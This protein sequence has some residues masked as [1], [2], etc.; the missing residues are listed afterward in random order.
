MVALLSTSPQVAGD[1]LL[2][3]VYSQHVDLGQRMFCLDAMT[4]AAQEL[5]NEPVLPISLPPGEYSPCRLAWLY[6]TSPCTT[7]TMVLMQRFIDGHLI[8][9]IS[10]V[11]IL[12]PVLAL[13]RMRHLLEGYCVWAHAAS[14]WP[15]INKSDLSS[16]TTVSSPAPTDHGCAV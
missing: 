10:C 1:A 9:S 16:T 4:A 11:A 8:P 2:G 3:Q 14:T 15:L 7:R 6:R 13:A 5:S 12:Y